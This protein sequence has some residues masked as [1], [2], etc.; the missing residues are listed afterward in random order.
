[1]GA[2]RSPAPTPHLPLIACSARL[3]FMKPYLKRKCPPDDAMQVRR[4]KNARKFTVGDVTRYIAADYFGTTSSVSNVYASTLSAYPAARM[5]S[6]TAS[7]IDVR[8]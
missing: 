2:G 7:E 3:K 8:P 4:A 6:R 5:R 1:M